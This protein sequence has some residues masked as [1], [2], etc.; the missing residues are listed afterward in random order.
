MCYCFEVPCAA[1]QKQLHYCS[2]TIREPLFISHLSSSVGAYHYVLG[3]V[4]QANSKLATVLRFG[5]FSA[6]H[7]SKLYTLA[8]LASY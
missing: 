3:L 2:A 6:V 5:Q 1:N 8:R 7:T 4:I